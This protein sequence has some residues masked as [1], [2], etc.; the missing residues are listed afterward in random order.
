MIKS[1]YKIK[2][3]TKT[4]AIYKNELKNSIYVPS[5]ERVINISKHFYKTGD[6]RFDT[7]IT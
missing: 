1:L 5:K 7:T 6:L 3:K 4:P 2:E